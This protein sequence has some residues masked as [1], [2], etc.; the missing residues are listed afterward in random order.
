MSR[1]YVYILRSH[2]TGKYY[3][4]QTKNLENRLSRHNKGRVRSTKSGRPWEL[5]VYYECTSRIEAMKL[6]KNLKKLKN[7]RSL[8]EYIT[9]NPGKILS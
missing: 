5:V 1:F 7:R 6:E 4:G 2:K 8:E 3:I 9:D